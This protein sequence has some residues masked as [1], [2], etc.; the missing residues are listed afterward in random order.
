M[1]VNLVV[2]TGIHQGKQIP[3]PGEQF[4]IGRD[5]SCQLR[6]ASQMVSKQHCAFVIKDEKVFLKDFGS[7]N[8]TFVNED[9]LVPN[10]IVQIRPG[11]RVKVGPL[12]FTVQFVG[13][14][15]S[16][17]TPLPD[18]LKAVTPAATKLAAAAG[19]K[20]PSGVTSSSASAT[21]TAAAPPPKL[22]SSSSSLKSAT[23]KE[24][25]DDI[26][27]ML[28]NMEDDSPATVPDGSTIMEM[29][30][31][32]AEATA[33]AGNTAA[34]KK[35]AAIPTREDSSNAASDILKKMMLRPR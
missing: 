22:S 11:D 15:A 8:G 20:T 1:Q 32:L 4:I 13:G 27:A 6:P 33:E 5:P 10:S 29:P 23:T 24:G 28:L 26:A 7:T 25:H 31:V 19:A 12:D 16:D 3:I 34:D 30:A 18:Q 9:Q 21:A 17:S 2:S 35:K 14:K